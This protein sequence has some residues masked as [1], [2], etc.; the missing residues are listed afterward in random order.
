MRIEHLEECIDLAETL[1]FTK[2]ARRFFVTQP[3]LSKHI[4][5]LEQ[6]LGV[7][8]FLRDQQRIR[9]T[10]I[11][12]QVIRDAKQTVNVYR[13]MLNNV[14]CYKEG[15][16]E[17]ISVG[18][19]LGA[20]GTLVTRAYPKFT[21]A[22]PEVDLRYHTFE[23]PEIYRT[24]VEDKVDVILSVVPDDLMGVDIEITPLYE[25]TFYFLV[26]SSHHLATAESIRP[27]DLAGQT[28]IL[29]TKAFWPNPSLDILSYLKPREN[30]IT[31]REVVEDMNT[32]AIL[33]A[34]ASDEYIGVTLGHLKHHYPEGYSLV[35][36]SGS[37]MKFT[38]AAMRKKS[39]E[40]PHIAQLIEQFERNVK[41][42]DLP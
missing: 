4:H 3:V 8:I 16:I 23:F 11:G 7:Q 12:E 2:T 36:L 14:T 13:R 41:Y 30:Q 10:E 32:L 19:L 42:I 24:L 40:K 9:L 18:F 21:K 27:S 38:I 33:M 17:S 20:A 35:P 15:L 26:P 1:N 34:S 22:H 37:D 6:E 5:G 39:N 25:D 29:H 31:T 28:V